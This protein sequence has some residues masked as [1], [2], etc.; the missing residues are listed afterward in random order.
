VLWS[1]LLFVSAGYSGDLNKSFP[2]VTELIDTSRGSVGSTSSSLLDRVKARDD[3]AWRRLVGVYGHLVLYWCRGAGLRRE[4][5]VDICQDVFRAVASNID[6]F[7]RD[8]V[9][10]SFRGWLRTI[11]RSKVVDHVRRQNR[12][13]AATGGSD[14]RDRLLAI[15][16]NDASSVPEASGQ[17][18]AILV[19]Q[20]LDLIRPEFE[21][22]TW[23][24]FWR[25]TAEG[26]QSGAVAEALE[27]TPGAVRQAKSRVLRRLREELNE[28]LEP[29]GCSLEEIRDS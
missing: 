11:T 3:A 13:P 18:K 21:D 22:R 17:E 25:A 19:N 7:R 1:A 27:M 14:A 4:D 28:L 24:A 29:G 26:Q 2:I 10:G 16:D 6:G 15:P 8:Q 12:Q 5:R 20:T 23:Q 9:G